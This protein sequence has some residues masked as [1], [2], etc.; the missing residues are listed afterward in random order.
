MKIE[1]YQRIFDVISDTQ[2]IVKYLIIFVQ[3]LFRPL[4]TTSPFV[5]FVA[6]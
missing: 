4:S 1:A 3:S 5:I 2:A 6:R